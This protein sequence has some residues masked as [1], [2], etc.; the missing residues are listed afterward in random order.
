MA[1]SQRSLD[2]TS[3]KSSA[4]A[5]NRILNALPISIGGALHPAS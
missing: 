1:L 5:N 2:T 4:V 3:W